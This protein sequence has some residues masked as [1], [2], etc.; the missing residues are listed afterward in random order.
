MGGNIDETESTQHDTVHEETENDISSFCR[1][2]LSKC[3][4]TKMTS[5]SV[6]LDFAIC[7]QFCE[8]LEHVAS[9]PSQTFFLTHTAIR[10]EIGC[11]LVREAVHKAK[12]V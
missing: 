2:A 9:M 3:E 5:A 1:P 7:E 4:H 10:R 8:L 6:L 11:H 12:S